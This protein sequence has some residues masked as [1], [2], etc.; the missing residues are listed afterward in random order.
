MKYG[1]SIL[2]GVVVLASAAFAVLQHEVLAPPAV[3]LAAPVDVADGEQATRLR[4]LEQRI[5]ELQQRLNSAERRAAA[6]LVDYRASD[7]RN[8]AQRAA[9]PA[10]SADVSEQP[11]VPHARAGLAPEERA[12]ADRAYREQVVTHLENQLVTEDYDSGWAGNFQA[13]LDQGLKSQSFSGTRLTGVECKS[14][15]CRVTLGHDNVESE[16]QFF[17]HVLELPMMANTQA[18][19]TRESGADGSSALVLYV[20]REGQALGL[21]KH[22]GTSAL[23]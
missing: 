23:N 12:A 4:Q 13:D 6:E 22:T 18:Y 2:V 8:D 17:E 7:E 11:P 15:L 21:P 14:S 10:Q 1:S 9:A 3:A 20:A 19:Y 5:G 16:E